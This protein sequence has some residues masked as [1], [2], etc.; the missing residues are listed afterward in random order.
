MASSI[1]DLNRSPEDSQPHPGSPSDILVRALEA[2]VRHQEALLQAL[3]IGAE[4]FLRTARWEAA[5]GDLLAEVGTSVAA[6]RV[7]LY[8]WFSNSDQLALSHAWSNGIGDPAASYDLGLLAAS[9]WQ[10]V[11]RTGSTQLIR[12]DDVPG[13]ETRLLTS[14]GVA[15]CLFVPVIKGEQVWGI[16]RLDAAS[17]ASEWTEGDLAVVRGAAT[18]IGASVQKETSERR[19]READERYRTLVEQVPAVVYHCEAG[20]DGTWLYVSPHIQSVLG[21]SPDEWLQQPNPL[22][23]YL[24]PDDREWVIMEKARVFT[25]GRS[26]VSEYRL[27]APDGRTIWIVDRFSAFGDDYGMPKW[28]H[29]VMTD[30]TEVREAREALAAAEIAEAELRSSLAAE[31]SAAERLRTLDEM[32]S[33]F[34]TAISHELRTPVQVI[35]GAASTLLNADRLDLSPEDRIRFT[36]S[37]ETKGRRLAQL[38]RDVVDVDRLNR[39]VVRFD[40]RMTRLDELIEA[41]VADVDILADHAL[42]VELDAGSAPVDPALIERVLENLLANAARHTPAGTDVWVRLRANSGGVLIVV[43]DAGPGV[44]LDK[45]ELIFTPFGQGQVQAHAPG[46]GVGLSLVARFVDLHGGRVWVED[47]PGGGASFRVLLPNDPP[48]GPVDRA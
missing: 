21:L 46:L 20:E 42:H 8:R 44:P 18:L 31:R 27:I 23:T 25:E 43:E 12:T 39:G 3:A 28:L 19:A 15:R 24:H 32:K 26:F 34:L 22:R 33:A 1:E 47:R 11:L 40:P 5:A 29:G 7:G 37:I 17:S 35:V 4:R 10:E 2:Q 48:E 41:V 36:S 14:E 38:L 13:P 9:R 16:L 6:D 30:V 45:R